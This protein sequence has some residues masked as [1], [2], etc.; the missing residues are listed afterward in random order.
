MTIDLTNSTIGNYVNDISNNF[1]R[2]IVSPLNAFGLG[3]FVF[4]IDG[5]STTTLS[6][7]ITDHYAEDNTT[8]NDNIAVK[9]TIVLLKNYVGEVVDRRDNST[10]TPVQQVVQK[11]TTLNSYLPPLAQA[12]T[13]LQSVLNTPTT[14]DSIA[15]VTNP[16]ANLYALV[17]NALQNTSRQKQAYQFFK[18]LRDQKILVGVQT[19]HEFLTNMAVKDVIAIQGEGTKYMSSFAI[20]LKQMRFAQTITVSGLF[21]QNASNPAAATPSTQADAQG[22][23]VE[24]SQDTVQLGATNGTQPSDAQEGVL[25]GSGSFLDIA[26]GGSL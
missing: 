21:A 19:A 3:G 15:N 4:D 1:N 6:T 24:Q 17:K 12:A 20:T 11:L 16:A 13:Q 7:D 5:E 2:A 10:N 8:I 26:P 22:R 23:N 18:A 14:L 25:S 9:P